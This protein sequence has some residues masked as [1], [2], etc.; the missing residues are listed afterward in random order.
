MLFAYSKTDKKSYATLG[1]AWPSGIFSACGFM[2]REIES[3]QG[4]GW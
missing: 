1:A 3:R 2:A 4:I